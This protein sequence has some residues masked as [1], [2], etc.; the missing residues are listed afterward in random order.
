MMRR[1]TDTGTGPLSDGR[2]IAADHDAFMTRNRNGSTR[3]PTDDDR[4]FFD[5]LVLLR[6]IYAERGPQDSMPVATI[7]SVIA[8]ASSSLRIGLAPLP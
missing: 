1:L 6:G 3:R 7:S 5:V 4:R 8:S 2:A